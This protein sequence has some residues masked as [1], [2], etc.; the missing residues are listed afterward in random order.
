MFRNITLSDPSLNYDINRNI[1]EDALLSVN[2]ESDNCK[3][4][5]NTTN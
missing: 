4:V 1:L 5:L 2:D 3:F